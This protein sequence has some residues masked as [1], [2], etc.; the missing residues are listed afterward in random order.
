MTMW[1]NN[2]TIDSVIELHYSGYININYLITIILIN[3]AQLNVKIIF[4][5][6][7]IIMQKHMIVKQ[8]KQ[9]LLFG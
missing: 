1:K 8:I 7:I 6:S 3:L 5:N 2:N 9:P 4:I